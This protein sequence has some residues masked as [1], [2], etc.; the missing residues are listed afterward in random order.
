MTKE[1]EDTKTEEPLSKSAVEGFVMPDGID[2]KEFSDGDTLTSSRAE[3]V[4]NFL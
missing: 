1:N 2:M 4:G 3:S